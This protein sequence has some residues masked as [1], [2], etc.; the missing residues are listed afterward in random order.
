MF[1]YAYVAFIACIKGI[2]LRLC[3]S[4]TATTRGLCGTYHRDAP[5]GTFISIYG[6][7][8]NGDKILK[9][10]WVTQAV[11]LHVLLYMVERASPGSAQLTKTLL[12]FA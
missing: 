12:L 10:D 6:P 3:Q 8:G 9:V 7:K 4:D 2:K 11:F 5:M 1:Y